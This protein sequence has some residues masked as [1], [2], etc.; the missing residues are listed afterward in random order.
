MKDP[1][2]ISKLVGGH[3]IETQRSH[4]PRYPIRRIA[5]IPT[6][7]P[8]ANQLLRKSKQFPL[9]TVEFHF[10]Q[11]VHVIP[12]VRSMLDAFPFS[13][14]HAIAPFGASVRVGAVIVRSNEED[15][16]GKVAD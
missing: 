8:R 16:Q 5:F 10:Q 12:F 7:A 15:T 14:A 4:L 3:L 1:H 13:K 9:Q 6:Q 2:H 11:I